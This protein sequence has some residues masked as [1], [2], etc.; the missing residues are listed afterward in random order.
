MLAAYALSIGCGSILVP[1]VTSSLLERNQSMG[2]MEIG[3]LKNAGR[4]IGVLERLL[5][6][7]LIICWPKLDAATIGLIFSAKSIAR[8]PEFKKQH[9][10]EYYLIGTLTSFIVAIAAG[11]IARFYL[12]N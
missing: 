9:F 11:I 10:A 7:T 6:T 8:F 5:I 2:Q 4:Y 12:L 3:G 1:L